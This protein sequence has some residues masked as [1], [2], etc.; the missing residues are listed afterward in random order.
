MEKENEIASRPIGY[1][2][3]VGSRFAALLGSKGLHTV[4]DM[5]YFLPIRYEDKRTVK[6]IGD[7][8]EGEKVL[9]VA[10]VVSSRPVF[11]PRARKRG[12]EATVKDDTGSLT[13]RWFNGAV[14]YLRDL[15]AKGN[16]LLL[17]G[18]VTRL[19]SALQIIHPE[20]VVL[21]DPDELAVL[22]KII[23]VYPELKGIKQGVVR[24]I[25]QQAL[26]DY[27][28]YV[29]SIIP[30][31]FGSTLAMVPLGETLRRLH[32]PDEEVMEDTIRQDYL[33]RLIFE[34]YLFFQLSI[35]IKRRHVKNEEGIGY[36]CT[37]HY[38]NVLEKMLPFELTEGQRKVIH[39]IEEDMQSKAPMNRLLQGDVGSGKTICAL[40]A[41]C[42]AVDNGY[43]VAFM[44]PTEI[45]AEQHFLTIH[46]FFDTMGIPV[47]C[48]HGNMKKERA[49]I[50]AAIKNGGI[51]VIVGTHALLQGDVAFNKLGLVIIDEQ[52]RFGVVQKKVLREK[53]LRPDTLVMTATPIPRTL[54]MVVYGDLDVSVINEL[55]PGRAKIVTRVF[56]DHKRNEVYR[57]V[58]E[59]LK[60]EGQVFIVCPLVE[61]S[62]TREL[63][64]AT[65][66]AESLQETIFS[67]RK[68]G[69]L[70]GRMS[71][72]E[73]ERVML[74][75]R[76]KLI[77]V[78][79]CTT[80]VEVGIDV[81][82]ATVIIIE[83]AERFGLSQLHQLRG[84]VGRGGRPSRCF[85]MVSGKLSA[86]ARQRLK[87]M[88]K[89]I[90]GFTISEEDLR[91]R[92]PGELFGLKQSGIPQFR[93]GSLIRDGDLMR[94]AKKTAEEIFRQ[95]PQEDVDEIR[96]RV[97]RKWGDSLHLSDIA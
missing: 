97:E 95:L 15:C 25:I 14:P 27:G 24:K 75:F 18:R 88:E 73:K 96:H 76:E 85:L 32:C 68:V 90:D 11:Y 72:E 6:N 39:E 63:L 19:G 9:V 28:R 37:G 17:S 41:S 54:S 4:E 46:T 62:S 91:L 58:E 31:D 60:R 56:P 59:E 33:R 57:Q 83:H 40:V 30:P 51:P 79:V 66:M 8:A 38:R 1:V 64:N 77:H 53:G 93:L 67:H 12:F 7:S 47:T 36:I 50:M 87:V 2:K 13:L 44:A 80:V 61:E 70:H 71:P 78:L 45:L 34:E 86:L 16:Y 49:G 26:N 10:R 69:L 55:P 43:Q 81:P 94:K 5:L 42:I 52:H 74:Q 21:E 22:Q 84:R 48:I 3:G 35:Q 65:S 92:G 23:P 29:R 20:T 82:D 89:T